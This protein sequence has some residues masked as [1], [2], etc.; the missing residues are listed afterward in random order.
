MANVSVS[1]QDLEAKAR[2]FRNHQ[3]E[4]EG[5]LT[6]LKGKVDQLVSGGFVTDAASGQF[7]ASYDELKRGLSSALEGLDGLATYLEKA[8]ETF[9]NVDDELARALR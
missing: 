9:R 7:Q 3:T 2:E 6:T 8:A 4:I 5:Q 1:Y